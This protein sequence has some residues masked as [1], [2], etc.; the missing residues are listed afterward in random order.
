VETGCEYHLKAGTFEKRFYGAG[1][2]WPPIKAT[3]FGA[4]FCLLYGWAMLMAGWVLQAKII[5]T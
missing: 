3:M 5:Q 4:S 1:N 2:N